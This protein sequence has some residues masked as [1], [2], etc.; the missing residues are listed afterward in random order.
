MNKKKILAQLTILSMLFIGC[1]NISIEDNSSN[2][3]DEAIKEQT[4][5]KIQND[6]SEII[7]K[8]YNYVLDNLGE[9]N[10]TTYWTEIKNIDKINTL[11]E[12]KQIS[13]VDLY[14]FKNIS[15]E[16][17]LNST[18]F[19]RLKDGLVKKAE[20]IDYSKEAM[21]DELY[22]SKV[23][24]GIYRDYDELDLN[25]IKKNDLEAFK[26]LRY[27]DCEK[28]VGKNQYIYD[29]YFYDEIG[30]GVEIFQIKDSEEKLC[31]F[32]EGDII[33][34]VKLFNN[35]DNDINEFKKVILK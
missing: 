14:Y 4:M 5:T 28:L 27:D 17:S 32:I 22:E 24:V 7:D 6:T 33:T 16:E 23:A 29:I 15:E 25:E 12:A 11:E 8:D 19:L 18:L 26:G 10:V 31:I 21:L 34:S 20:D 9:A 30:R 3:S 13:N 2:V 1:S 35:N